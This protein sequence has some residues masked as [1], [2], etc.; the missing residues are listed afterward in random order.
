MLRLVVFWFLLVFL[1]L[2]GV[3]L[4]FMDPIVLIH[5]CWRKCFSYSYAFWSL[6]VFCFLLLLDCTDMG[7]LEFRV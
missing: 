4:I 2:S 7:I 5:R 6:L 3:A 1:F